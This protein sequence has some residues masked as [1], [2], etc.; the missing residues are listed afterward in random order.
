MLKPIIKSSGTTGSER[1]LARLCSRTFLSLWSY[2]NLYTDEGRK[3]G[4]GHGKELCDLLVVFD[5]H[6]LIFSDKLVRFKETG[7]IKIDWRRWFKK[8]IWKSANQI[9]GA[10]R[11]IKGFANRIY[12]DREC[13]HAFPHPIAEIE[14]PEIHRIVV[15]T[16]TKE[17]AERYFGGGSSGSLMLV[18]PIIG[19]EHLEQP[20]LIGQINPA[21]GF[22]H[23]FDE[24]SLDV[25]MN[26]LDTA[27]DLIAYLS[28]KERA[29]SQ[30]I[31]QSI[32]GE[33]DLLGYYM[34]NMD[35]SLQSRFE[36]ADYLREHFSSMNLGEGI[37]KEYIVSR[38]RKALK[39]SKQISNFWDELIERF[40][41]GILN[42][43]VGLAH[44][45]SFVSHERAVRMLASEGRIARY[46]LANSFL[47]K[48]F[49]VPHNRRSSRLCASPTFSD[50]CYIF[51]FYPRDPGE[52][53]E[54]YRNERV[55]ILDLYG[56]ICKYKFPQFR[57]FVIIGTE[58]MRSEKRSEDILV[59]DI[60]ELS[61][62]EKTEAEKISR[63]E[64]ILD[65]VL[66]RKHMEAML[67]G[68]KQKDVR[69][70][71]RKIGRN[72]PCPCGSGKKYKKC[73]GHN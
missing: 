61:E 9:Y 20:F 69:K 60:P 25:V 27:P 71:C 24:L 48:V 10:E 12:L 21:K 11:W 39:D 57:Y 29:I 14:N 38:E 26:E 70:R 36:I 50:R 49:E 8:A 63:E 54:K 2:P 41:K 58:P 68:I 51:V 35:S 1:Y 15:V 18:P 46:V 32:A 3:D 31:F 16:N 53:Y 59:L 43:T 44:K 7:D 5:N 17:I 30:K 45:E 23:V 34:M 42:A 40:S 22:V 6:I 67:P 13:Q 55:D 28:E 73:C 52:D 66:P 33:E 65:N 62:S 47:E 19:E 72:Q 4:K 37:W 56:V 64:H